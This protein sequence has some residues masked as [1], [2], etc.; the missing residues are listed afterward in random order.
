MM[1]KTTKCIAVFACFVIAAIGIRVHALADTVNLYANLDDSNT[2]CNILIDAMYND[3]KYDPYNQYAVMRTGEYEYRVY[4]GDDLSG[5]NLVY[6]QYVPAQ[7]QIPASISRGTANSLTIN[8]HGYYFVGNVEGSL[9][10]AQAEN[11]KT[12]VIISMA[13][14]AILFVILFVRFRHSEGRKAKYYSVR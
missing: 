9:S 1:S 14:I 13:A 7:Y 2:S 11:Y 6:Y 10:S 3:P 12:G 5:S 4:F 8:R